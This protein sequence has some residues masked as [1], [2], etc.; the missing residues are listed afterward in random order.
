MIGYTSDY[1]RWV[2]LCQPFVALWLILFGAMQGAGYTLA[3]D[4]QHAYFDAFQ[5]ASGLVLERHSQLGPSGT[6][7]GVSISVFIVGALAIWRFNTGV[8]RDQKV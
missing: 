3:D 6:W 5:A 4:C 8:W 1:F 7:A 2:G